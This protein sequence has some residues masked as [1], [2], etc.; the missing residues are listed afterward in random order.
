M[1]I[2]T[3]EQV[4]P[5]F[6]PQKKLH[7]LAHATQVLKMMRDDILRVSK[8]LLECNS[9]T[10]CCFSNVCSTTRIRIKVKLDHFVLVLLQENSGSLIAFCL[11]QV[12]C[13]NSSSANRFKVSTDKFRVH[14]ES[15][16]IPPG[17]VLAILIYRNYCIRTVFLINFHKAYRVIKCRKLRTSI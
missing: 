13:Y 2:R 9:L 7:I 10:I 12:S 4:L 16:V 1:F 17:Y 3:S 8:F 11:C 15:Y 5:G 6:T 14:C